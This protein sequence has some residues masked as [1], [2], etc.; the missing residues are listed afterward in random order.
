[1]Q[2]NGGNGRCGPLPDSCVA[3]NGDLFDHL[4]GAREQCWGQ[5]KQGWYPYRP[6]AA[7]HAVLRQEIAK[8]LDSPPSWPGHTPSDDEKQAVIDL[9]KAELAL[10]LLRLCTLTLRIMPQAQWITAWEFRGPNSTIRRRSTIES[11]F[12]H[13][14]PHFRLDN[15]IA[16]AFIKELESL[17]RTAIER[18][19]DKLRAR[20]HK[21]EPNIRVA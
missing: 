1:M 16:V 2:R 21:T 3:A 18:A 19:I 15:A 10:P 20:T 7:L 17:V 13:H 9:I 14:V 4:V 11:L 12:A 8:F 6:V 5:L